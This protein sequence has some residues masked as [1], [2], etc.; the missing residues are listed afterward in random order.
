LPL[1]FRHA[2]EIS[3]LEFNRSGTKLAVGSKDRTA[4]VWN[5]LNGEPLTPPLLHGGELS[6][7][8]FSHDQRRVLTAS[9]D[10]T[11]RVW[12]AAT[13][14]PI[15]LPLVV[16]GLGRHW[17]EFSPEGRFILT[18]RETSVQLWDAETGVPVMRPIV[19][20]KDLVGASVS[21]D[22]RRL[23]VL[24]EDG[25]LR[26]YDV[27]PPDWSV[28]DWQFAAHFL[29]SQTVDASEEL[30]PWAGLVTSESVTNATARLEQDWL[31]LRQHLVELR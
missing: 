5:A 24:I 10:G 9:V 27:A 21:V 4:R 20:D 17:V 30:S 26:S 31:R 14:S 11:A 8:H 22:G 23:L 12:D 3:A 28:A 15:T 25:S 6:Q 7:V 1:H 18:R 2:G 13:G 29:S 19:S 16:A